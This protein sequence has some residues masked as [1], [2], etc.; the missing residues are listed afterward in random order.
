[1]D[2]DYDGPKEHEFRREKDKLVREHRKREFRVEN[3]V[4]VGWSFGEDDSDLSAE[5][6]V[7]Q[8]IAKN[9]YE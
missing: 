8:R 3:G 9:E 6:E 1:M 7:A 2:D 5:L 4:V